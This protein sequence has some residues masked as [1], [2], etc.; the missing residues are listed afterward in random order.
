[1]CN[2]KKALTYDEQ[3]DRLEQ[4][5]SLVINDREKAIEILKSVNY[6]RLSGYG[7][8]LKEPTDKEK[9]KKGI[10]LDLLYSLYKFDSNLRNILI[11]TI[12]FIEIEFRSHIA[13]LLATN[14]GA[15]G[16]T[17]VTNFT[18][19]ILKNNES[20]HSNI[21]KHLKEECDRQQNTPFVKHHINQY[22]GHFPI[23]VSIELFT[24]GN[25]AS[26][27]SIM[28]D[29]DKKSIGRLYKTSHS[30]LISWILS[31]VEARNICAHYGRLYNALLKQ[32]PALLAKHKKFRQKYNKLFP[33][34]LAM[35]Y[36]LFRNPDV[37]NDFY[38][39]LSKLIKANLSI[40]NLSFMG[41]PTNWEE[42]LN[43]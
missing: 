43:S 26:L 25:L 19:K 13:Y 1:M 21:I 39:K 40:V 7:I 31:L 23:W 22:N 32:A 15:E 10:S 36:I 42:I 11:H 3:V 20:V 9:Y 29:A 38:D 16:Y 8:G 33:V 4:Y 30:M 35:K 14:Y 17:D 12:E 18:D 5:H 2:L 37:W 24:F 28:Q 27:F 6:Y 41:F 34:I